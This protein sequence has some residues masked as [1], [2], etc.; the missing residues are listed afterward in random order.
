MLRGPLFLSTIQAGA[1]KSDLYAHWA[2]V[3]YGGTVD[4]VQLRRHQILERWEKNLQPDWKELHEQ[5]FEATQTLMKSTFPKHGTGN[6][7]LNVE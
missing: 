3:Q 2:D 6:A 4:L 5:G 7:L 1:R